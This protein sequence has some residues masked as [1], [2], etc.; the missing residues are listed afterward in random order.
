MDF[1]QQLRKQFKFLE[2]SCRIYDEGNLDEA[3][4]IATSIRVLLHNT[5]RSTS[6]LTHIK[7]AD[8]N[9]LSTCENIPQGA[10]FWA[11]LTQMQFSPQEGWAKF[12]PKLDSSKSRIQVSASKWWEGEIIYLINDLKI[13]RR[14]L[15][16]A[17]ADKDGGV[18]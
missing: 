10:R 15:V 17:A 2:A 13:F 16:L 9:L 18:S 11:N 14:D 1:K 5:K 4:R 3:T 6:L 8:I 12:I 7:L